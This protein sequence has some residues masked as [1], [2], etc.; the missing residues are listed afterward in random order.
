MGKC[1]EWNSV[2]VM[3]YQGLE[4]PCCRGMFVRGVES[5]EVGTK[6]GRQ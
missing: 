4:C 2:R 1:T 3:S 5:G 6:E